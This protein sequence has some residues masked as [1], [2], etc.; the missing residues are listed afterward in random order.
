MR[1]KRLLVLSFYP[2]FFPPRSGGETR[3]YNLYH[4]LADR[5]DIRILSSSHVDSDIDS[6][7][8]APFLVEHRYGKAAPFVDCYN[9]AAAI[10]GEGD[11]SGVAVG[12]YGAYPNDMHRGYADHY[13][14]ADIIIHESPFTVYFDLMLGLD[15]KPRV[16]DAHNAEHVLMRSLHPGEESQPIHEFVDAAERT[17]VNAADLV[18]YCADEDRAALE[19]L[20][21]RA[22][23]RALLVPNGS[24]LPHGERPAAVRRTARRLVFIGS[25]HA[26]NVEAARFLIEQV[27]PRLPDLELHIVG[28]CASPGRPRANVICHGEIDEPRK[29]E[30]FRQSDIALNP[31][32]SGSGS[33]L[34]VL[35]Y[36]GA[37]LPVVATA[38]GMRGIAAEAGR[39]YVRADVPDFAD[40]V[41][42]LSVDNDM[43]A[44][45]ADAATQHIHHSLT[46]P[47]IARA[48]GDALHALPAE[49]ADE[50]WVLCLNDYDPTAGFGGGVTRM[51]G[52]QRVLAEHARVVLL[53]FND[54]ETIER[55]W[56]TS[57]LLVIKVP[58]TPAHRAERRRLDALSGI[59]AGDVV[60]CR[61]AAGNPILMGLY[62]ILR[63][64][65]SV[66][67][68]EHPYMAPVAEEFGDAFVYSSQNDELALK[69]GLLAGH[70][71]QDDLLKIVREAE[72]FC[73]RAARLTVAVS[74]RDAG[75]FTRRQRPAGGPVVVVPNGADLP[76]D[77][78]SEDAACAADVGPRSAVF[79]GSAH[80]PNIEALRLLADVVA[81]ALPDVEFHV[82]GSVGTSAGN[83]P[84]NVRI[85]GEVEPG[86]K[87][88]ILRRAAIALN[89]I[90]SGGGSNVKLSDYLAHGL[91]TVTSAFGLRG[92]PDSVRAFVEVA[93]AD[94]IA[95]AIV[96]LLGRFPPCGAHRQAIADTFA[97]QLSMAVH[98]ARFADVVRSVDAP[99]RRMLVVT[100]RYTDPPLGGAEIMLRELLR[101]L[102]ATGRWAIDVVA[103]D[104]G[105][106]A[107]RSRFA[108]EY[109]NASEFGVA[110]D[111]AATRWR[112]F[113][114]EGDAATPE[115]ML[116]S[117]RVQTAF[118][119][120]LASDDAP[121]PTASV[122]RLLSGWYGPEPHKHGIAR[123]TTQCASFH[124]GA[125]GQLRLRGF[126]PRKTEFSLTCA[127][128]VL[129]ARVD[130][131][132]DFTA[133]MP[134]GVATLSVEARQLVSGD[135]RPLG[136]R[137]THLD[138]DGA[139]PLA[140]PTLAEGV[141]EL[142]FSDRIH[143]LD[144]AARSTRWPANVELTRLRGP[145][146]PELHDWLWGNI[147]RYDVLLTH[148]CVFLPP[149]QALRVAAERGVPSVFIPHVH[150]DD[151]FYHFPDVMSAI[152]QASVSLVSPHAA[153]DFLRARAA[154][155][156][157]Y[158][159]AGVEP[160]EFAADMA[161]R[162]LAAFRAVVSDDG[163]PVVLVLGRK[164]AAKN[165]ATALAAQR[166]L[167][168]RGI[169]VRVVMI[170]PDDDGVTVAAR[171]VVYLGLQP[172]DVVRGALRAA[173]ALVNMSTSESFGIVLLEAWLA[174]T[175][176]IANR[177]CVAFADLVE[178]G[179]NGFLV[180]DAPAIA[181]RLA[182][183]L[184]DPELG[185]AQ[186]ARGREVARHYAWSALADE[187]DTICRELADGAAEHAAAE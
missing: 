16:Y 2:C 145:N 122:P 41:A 137:V 83:V 85:W 113:A 131:D 161:D 138:I 39:H 140:G 129:G 171:D 10:G 35:D 28:A 49:P 81:P 118:E 62:R 9:A 80:R 142:P 158:F 43:R 23:R 121:A 50:G 52:V 19:T 175:P 143:A 96:R 180:D 111:L 128:A 77:P 31:V 130:G 119:D 12:V 70:S 126:A 167:A 53:C 139:S 34:K 67:V 162:D 32:V 56:I 18:A 106:I 125:G 61:F 155:R 152:E 25:R 157:R 185:A 75:A 7:V 120:A 46:W 74:D 182:R 184:N 115:E 48:F 42:A 134:P 68:L 124:T 11:L 94:G 151:D 159:G 146:A 99:R 88:A 132:F 173:C 57:R 13:D 66:I 59:S 177:G 21:G 5:F 114:L 98:A 110:T 149:V 55:V 102:D 101:R 150:L 6:I 64:R 82:L 26:P 95:A 165:Y 127:D 60:N 30:I 160:A 170:G 168:A 144:R 4:A 163:T 40:A 116:E 181:D 186:A 91:P 135:V 37:G 8:H 93:D 109:G 86:L 100:Y 172:R 65:A 166:L 17:L 20:S 84:P 154:P 1:R 178:D 179:V 73:L 103:P 15:R 107:N 174:G 29:A 136:L 38:F 183:L 45:I 71:E 147:D 117:W 90:Y 47:A 79:L 14:W 76:A 78:S 36:M 92:Y 112:R 24:A 104:V 133:A 164:A 89:P 33:N 58:K 44:S 63:R 153:A 22:L 187:L 69:T 54:G 141:S 51:L 3:L 97:R 156:V 148:N 72:D 123:W 87:T 27:A 176:V 105:T 169:A 108:C